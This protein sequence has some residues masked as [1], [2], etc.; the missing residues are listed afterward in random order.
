MFFRG[1]H[2]IQCSRAALAWMY[3]D[4]NILD[5]C[6]FWLG[7]GVRGCGRWVRGSLEVPFVHSLQHEDADVQDEIRHGRQLTLL[8][9]L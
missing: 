7:H 4:T 3:V 5:V 8:A 1:E 9:L 6:K 2:R